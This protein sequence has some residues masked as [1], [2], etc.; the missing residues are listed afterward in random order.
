MPIPIP[1][2]QKLVE[3]DI[4]G[5]DFGVKLKGYISDAAVTVPLGKISREAE[6]L[7][8]VTRECLAHGIDFEIGM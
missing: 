2:K 6:K 5:I 7:L 8:E 3:G 4:L 1:N